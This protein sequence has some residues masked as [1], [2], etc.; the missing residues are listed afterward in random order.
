MAFGGLFRRM[1]LGLEAMRCREGSLFSYT[2][3]IGD[4]GFRWTLPA[5]APRL[6]VMRCREGSVF[7]YTRRYRR[8]WPTVD[9]RAARRNAWA[10]RAM[11]SWTSRRSGVA[12]FRAGASV[13]ADGRYA[14]M[15]RRGPQ[16]AVI[17]GGATL[18]LS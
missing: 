8:P 2:S 3:G 9:A 4:S 7:S 1:I 16:V 6:V 10:D 17:S 5:N 11:A 13:P 14:P 15:P 12:A 18:V